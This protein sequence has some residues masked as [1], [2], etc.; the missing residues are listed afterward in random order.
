MT[1]R[2]RLLGFGQILFSHGYNAPR[3]VGHFLKRRLAVR[4][5][6]VRWFHSPTEPRI[7][8]MERFELLA[9][10]PIELPLCQVAPYAQL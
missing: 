7:E 3:E 9:H 1:L 10:K 2:L 6:R 4:S 8:V 5:W